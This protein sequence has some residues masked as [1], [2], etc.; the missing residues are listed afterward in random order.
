[1]QP[2]ISKS[3]SALAHVGLLYAAAVWGATFF[4]VKD[5]LANVDPIVLVGY[6]FL[7]AGGVLGGWLVLKGQSLRDGLK[8]AIFVGILLWLLYVPQTIGLQYTTAS[9]SGFITGLFVAFV[10]LFLRTIFKR[11]PTLMELAASVISLIGLWILTGGMHDINVGDMLTLVTAVMY[12]VHLLYADR[13]LKAG[14]DP[15]VF[16]CQQF[17]V[18]GILSVVVAGVTGRSFAVGSTGAV[19][20]ILFLAVFP[21][22]LA[23]IAQM[24]GQKLI[25]PLRVTLVF[26]LEPVFAG[27]FA[28]TLGGEG[29]VTHRALGGLLIFVALIVS[30]LPTPR[31]LRRAVSQPPT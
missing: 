12:A 5:T 26:A 6:R 29:F 23:F 13:Y 15:F 7:I 21:T 2:N 16:T 1:M 30:G 3:K 25:S 27:L 22:L 17:I 31:A 18:V 10:P 14:A 9:N 4:I 8:P 28:W 19:W 24:V 20:T 11:T